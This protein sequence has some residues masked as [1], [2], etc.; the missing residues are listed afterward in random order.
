VAPKGPVRVPQLVQTVEDTVEPIPELARPSLRMLIETLRG[1]D[2]QIARLDSEIAERAKK[3]ET[4]RRST[5]IPGVCPVTAVALAALAPPAETFKQ[6]RDIAAWIGLSPLQHSTGG[7]QKLGATSKMGERTLRRLLIIGASAVFQWAAR[8]GEPRQVR[9]SRGPWPARRRCWC[10]WPWPTSWLGSSGLS[11][12]EV[13][14]IR[15]QPRRR[16]SRLWGCWGVGRSKERDGATVNETGSGKP[17]LRQ[18]LQAR[19]S[20]LDLIRELPSGPAACE[21]Q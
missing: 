20:D 7:K 10:G 6:G 15:L 17:A 21:P 14:F 18:V 1:L 2:E 5:T 19:G 12:R 3:D 16:R 4:A 8:N 9:G 13:E 11:W